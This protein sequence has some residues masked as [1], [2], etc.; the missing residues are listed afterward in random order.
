MSVTQ[1]RR[2]QTHTAPAGL[3]GSGDSLSL[4]SVRGYLRALE[5][6]FVVVDLPSWRYQIRSRSQLLAAPTRHFVDPSLAVA[7]LGTSPEDLE[8][9]P[10]T[11]GFLFESLCV[12]DLRVY[13]QA[14][15]ANVHHYRDN[16]GLEADA[17]VMTRSGKWGA[18]E[19]KLDWKRADN[20]AHSLLR[21]KNK[22]RGQIIDPSFLMILTA[23]GGVAHTRPD[24]VHVVPLDCLGP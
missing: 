10:K 15:D 5:S 17:I 12:R 4:T 9:D 1:T 18:V 2:Q 20:A 19:V 13:S 22:L 24:G 11:T 23:T 7:A 6:I 14:N 8:A 21:L 16:K 3:V